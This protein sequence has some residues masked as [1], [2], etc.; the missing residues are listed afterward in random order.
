V[1][2]DLG[3]E[4]ASADI[5]ITELVDLDFVALDFETSGYRP[6]RP[7]IRIVELAAVKFDLNGINDVSIHGSGLGDR[8]PSQSAS[9]WGR[10]RQRYALGEWD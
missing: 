9:R 4:M 3:K 1:N 8:P 7:A 2:C 6:T 5:K 10:N